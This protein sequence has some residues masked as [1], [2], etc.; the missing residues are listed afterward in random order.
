VT[1][2]PAPRGDVGPGRRIVGLDGDEP[3]EADI[4]DVAGQVEDR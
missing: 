1:P 4:A 3:I 2:H